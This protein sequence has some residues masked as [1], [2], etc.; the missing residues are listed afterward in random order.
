[1]S[2][3]GAIENIDDFVKSELLIV[4]VLNLHRNCQ[5]ITMNYKV[6][7]GAAK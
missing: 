2:I 4:L 3:T 1:M 6:F 7:G 5:G